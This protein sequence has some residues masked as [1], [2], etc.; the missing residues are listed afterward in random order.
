MPIQL[1]VFLFRKIHLKH[2]SFFGLWDGAISYIFCTKQTGLPP[3]LYSIKAY[4]KPYS[5]RVNVVT[6]ICFYHSSSDCDRVLVGSVY[7]CLTLVTT[8]PVTPTLLRS[9]TFDTLAN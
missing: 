9:T 7:R 4:F 6:Y 1:C 8:T 5:H 2:K 3:P